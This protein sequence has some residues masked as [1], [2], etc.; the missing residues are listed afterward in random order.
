M[1]ALWSD[2]PKCSHSVSQKVKR[3]RRF[4]E[5]CHIG[6]EGFSFVPPWIYWLKFVEA[7]FR[8]SLRDNARQ[9]FRGKKSVETLGAQASLNPL[10][11]KLCFMHWACVSIVLIPPLL[12]SVWYVTKRQICSLPLLG[13]SN[14]ALH[15]SLRLA[16]PFWPLHTRM[17]GCPGPRAW[18]WMKTSLNQSRSKVSI[19][20][21]ERS[22]DQYRSRP[23]VSE[24]F[25]RHWS[26]P[27]PGE[28]HMDQ[29]LVHT[30]SWENSYGPMVLKVLQKL[31]PALV[32]VHG[33]LFPDLDLQ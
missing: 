14:F 2:R 3:I 22:M 29:S 5:L 9:D 25:E 27:F 24:N 17:H 4:S 16:L 19:F 13:W 15:I 28:I 21:E 12:S 30:F 11:F 1:R 33:W 26:I 32:L 6:T 18:R 23:K 10:F 31:P 8:W 20:R 7:I